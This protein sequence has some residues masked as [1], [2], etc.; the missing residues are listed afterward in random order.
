M[1]T[2]HY[3]YFIMREIIIPIITSACEDSL[4]LESTKINLIICAFLLKK[5]WRINMNGKQRLLI[6]S[7]SI[8]SAILIHEF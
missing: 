8:F 5:Q 6:F 4:V 7:V 1:R 2:T 3:I